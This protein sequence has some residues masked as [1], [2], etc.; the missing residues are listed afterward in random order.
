M[1]G[2]SLA[3]AYSGLFLHR[4]SMPQVGLLGTI[5]RSTANC[6]TESPKVEFTFQV[7]IVLILAIFIAYATVGDEIGEVLARITDFFHPTDRAL[8]NIHKQV[9]L[10]SSQSQS[11]SE[12]E[13]VN[14][15]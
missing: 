4:L 13:R 8:R 2:I 11:E 7:A 6:I 5:E 12:K 14:R 9:R 3:G 1:S 10:N 15:P